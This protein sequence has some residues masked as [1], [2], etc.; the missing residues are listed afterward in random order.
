[1]FRHEAEATIYI[2]IIIPGGPELGWFNRENQNWEI[3]LFNYFYKFVQLTKY[4]FSFEWKL[5]FLSLRIKGF[6]HYFLSS[7]ITNLKKMRIWTFTAAKKLW[8]LNVLNESAIKV[9]EPLR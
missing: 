6:A 4:H 3:Q 5:I 2:W 1:M 7:L 9:V 8:M